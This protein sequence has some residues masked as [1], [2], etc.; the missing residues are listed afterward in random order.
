MRHTLILAMVC[1]AAAQDQY[2]LLLKGGHVIDARNGI[3][4][5]R[6]VAIA[7]GKIAAVEQ[8]IQA[9]RARKTVPKPPDP[10]LE[11]IWY[12][13]TTWPSRWSASG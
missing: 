7:Q 12:F 3:S 9:S 5:V 2:D 4:A 10:R 11:R 13:P 8:N 6:D 1:C